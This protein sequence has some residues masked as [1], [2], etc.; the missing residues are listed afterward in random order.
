M[1]KNYEHLETMYKLIGQTR[2]IVGGKGE[3]KLAFMQIWGFYVTGFEELAHKAIYH[4]V[5][6]SSNEHPYGS[7]KDIKYFSLYIFNLAHFLE[8]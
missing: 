6:N 8:T 1:N 7:W 3:Q 2:D 4:F 5:E